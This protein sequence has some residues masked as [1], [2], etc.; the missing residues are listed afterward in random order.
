M[1][2]IAGYLL[3]RGIA[4]AATVHRMCA[5]IV[6]RGPDDEGVRVSGGCGIGMRRL[7][8]IDLVSGHQ[9]LS[10][11]DG[12]IWIVFNG[13]IYSYQDL[14][15][16]L[17][18]QGHSFQ[19]NSDTET[20]VHLYEQDGVEGVKHLRGMFAYC[21]WDER[22]QQLYL[23][24]DRF[25]K[26]PL[27]Y[28]QTAT[29]FYFASELKCLRAANVPLE[30]DDHALRL[31]LQFGYVPEPWSI[32]KGVRKLP[33]GCWMTVDRAGRIEQG[34]YWS[35]PPPIEQ[36]ASGFTEKQATEEIRRVFDE[37]VRLRMISDVPLGAFLSGGIDS[38]LVVASMALQSKE[39]VRTFSMGF[40]DVE[41]NELP[42]ARIV[43]KQYGT[44]HHEIMV[45]PDQV[46][47]ISKIIHHCDEPFADS[48]AI[49]TYLVSEA[50]AKHVKVA[51]SGDGGDEFFGGYWSFFDA[52]RRR[53]FDQIPGFIRKALSGV[54]N[55][56]PYGTKGKNYLRAM[57]R[58]N[59]LERYFESGTLTMYFQRQQV[60]N[61]EWMLPD[62]GEFLRETF[63][64]AILDGADP[65][66]E[67]MHFEATA[68]MTGD[69]LVKVDRMSMAN[70]LEVRSPLLDQEFVAVAAKIPNRWKM[71]D[72]K[73][74]LI[75]LKAL[76]DRIP[77]ELLNRPKRGFEVP[78][79]NWFRGPLRE[80]LRDNL[81][82]S[83]FRDR[84]ITVASQVDALLDEHNSGRRDN[85]VF[86]WLLLVL[87]LWLE[88][89]RSMV[90]MT[91]M[92]S[93]CSP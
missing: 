65:V 64:D 39:P 87:A 62:N 44:D 52:E 46:S 17:I 45:K 88:E 89:Q 72:G 90:E 93:A 37:S 23:A 70:S 20:I 31:Y 76:G 84:G 27:Y 10:N 32:Y 85:S 40:D 80:Y 74:K 82:S 50:A 56:L 34:R 91:P 25:G 30:I 53:R 68:K 66:S 49:P 4:E 71:R 47:L 21:L 41:F 51:L 54:A 92:G 59:S 29:G 18:S 19:T 9:P 38:T 8:I 2:G 75:L 81:T 5:Q 42:Y 24:R 78:L 77:A 36:E 11:E 26:K 16:R 55:R 86:L 63:G 57:S 3:E 48:S 15:Q 79:G 28:T 12:S 67:A 83:S 60:L 1:C 6:H 61:P 7:A 22:K 43:A 69:I 14:R 35:V 73:G 13:E 58:G 33:A